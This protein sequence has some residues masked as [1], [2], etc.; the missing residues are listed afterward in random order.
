LV[1]FVPA[2]ISGNSAMLTVGAG[3]MGLLIGFTIPY[4][5]SVG[6]GWFPDKSAAVTSMLFIFGYLSVAAYP[7]ASGLLG[8]RYGLIAAMMLV[9]VSQIVLFGVSW[10]LPGRETAPV[11][12]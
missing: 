6:C 5:M 9:V 11:S 1:I 8:D 2:L 4:L 3:F 7:W 10:L 12:D